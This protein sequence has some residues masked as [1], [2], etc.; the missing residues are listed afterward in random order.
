[1]TG[2]QILGMMGNHYLD[3]PTQIVFTQMLN[4]GI[5]QSLNLN[6]IQA[7]ETKVG[8]KFVME[9]LE[10]KGLPM[11]GEDSGHLIFKDF[12]PIGDGIVSALL[13]IK[14][15]VESNQNLA[16]L[17]NEFKPYPEILLNIKNIE[18]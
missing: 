11:G 10:E 15:M 8:D 14:L 9:T 7:I 2:D 5:K 12:W 13:I 17:A 1:M 3:S 18:A 16:Y 6:G 4:P